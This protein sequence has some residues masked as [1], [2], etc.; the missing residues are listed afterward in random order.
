MLKD[1][2][3]PLVILD[4]NAVWP[5]TDLELISPKLADV[6]KEC[7]R[8]AA[9]DVILPRMVFYEIVFQRYRKAQGFL[10]KAVGGLGA[11]K[12]LAGCE[13]P[14]VPSPFVVRLSIVRA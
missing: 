4:T 6:L 8:L 11:L 7:S 1:A 2:S 3:R 9:F 13:V 10:N 5:K 14:E 12:T